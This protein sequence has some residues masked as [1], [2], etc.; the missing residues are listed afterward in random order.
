MSFIKSLKNLFQHRYLIKSLTKKDLKVR[1]AGS[2]LGFLWSIIQPLTLLL[3]FSFVYSWMMKVRLDSDLGTENFTVWLYAGLLP[4][5]FFAE[6]ISRSSSVV[7]DYTNLIKKTVFPSEILPLVIICSN[8]VNFCVGFIILLS[9]LLLVGIPIYFTSLLYV[10]IIFLLLIMM[11]L[12][13]SWIVSCL[14]VYFRDLGQIVA[15]L[16]NIWFYLSAIIFPM[17]VVPEKYRGLFFWNPLTHVIDG[18]RMAL[19]N[20]QLL[21]FEGLQYL[22]IS[23]IVLFLAGFYLFQK[24]KKGFVDVL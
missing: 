12:G 21:N 11:I 10:L 2:V 23:A 7:V 15:V 6:S 3:V 20:N 9:S 22:A 18:F 13:I 14:N 24:T 1:Y 8:G 4:W 16:L 19:L 5:T 17:S